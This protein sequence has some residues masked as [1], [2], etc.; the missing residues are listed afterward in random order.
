MYTLVV[1][2]RSRFLY[3]AKQTRLFPMILK[4]FKAR[5]T[6]DS[7]ITAAKLRCGNSRLDILSRR[8]GRWKKTILTHSSP[9]SIFLFYKIIRIHLAIFKNL[10]FAKHRQTL[11]FVWKL[12]VCCLF[13]MTN[14][15][16]PSN[17]NWRIPENNMST[18][19]S[20]LGLD[21]A[22]LADVVS[23]TTINRLNQVFIWS[24]A[25]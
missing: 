22:L 23:G 9:C 15:S 7:V 12:Y 8:K 16:A 2:R 5:Q 18:I 6:L 4:M 14:L 17:E 25:N 11:S 20:S 1:D 21:R 13:G 24:K 19:D 3:T 10:L